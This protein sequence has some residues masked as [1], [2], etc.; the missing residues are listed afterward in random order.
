MSKSPFVEV[1]ITNSTKLAQDSQ[2][3]ADSAASEVT[4][5]NDHNL[6]SVIEKQTQR[7]QFV[8]LTSQYNVILNRAKDDNI[9]TT[10]LTTAYNNLNAFMSVI[11]TD[12]TKASDINRDTYNS[13]I[14]AY[15]TALSSVQS[16]LS[17]SYNNDISNMQSSVSTASQ[18]ASEAT[19]VASSAAAVGSNAADVGNQAL[20]A[21]KAAGDAYDK[22]KISNRNLA[23]MSAPGYVDT[24]STTDILLDNDALELSDPVW[25]SFDWKVTQAGNWRINQVQTN[26]SDLWNDIFIDSSN[27][28]TDITATSGNLSGH[29]S[30]LVYWYPI[31]AGTTQVRLHVN[32]TSP[33]G[34]LTINNF[35]LSNSSK[36]VM[37]TPAETVLSNAVIGTAQIKDAAI[38]DAKISNLSANKITAGTI[39]ASKITVTNIDA[40]KITVGKIGANQLQVGSLSA[41]S[42]D[43]GKVT[44][45]S[46]KG[47]DI[48]ANTFSTPDGSFTTD[49]NGAITAT[50]LT[51]LGNK[52]FVYNSELLG[53]A[54]GWSL[55]NGGHVVNNSAHAGTL[56]LNW[57]S[58]TNGAN[59]VRTARSKLMPVNYTNDT[60]FS[61]SAWLLVRQ[62]TEGI[63]F[64]VTIIFWD[65]SSNQVGSKGAS[66]TSDGNYQ[67]WTLLTIENLE[68]PS[69]ASYV[70]IDYNVYNGSGDFTFSQPMI[71]QGSKYQGYQP[72][73][74][75]VISA[76]EI[77]GSV[78]NGSTISGTT[79]NAGVKDTISTNVDSLYPLTISTSGILTANDFQSGVIN[80]ME[81]DGT[82]I[83]GKSRY[84]VANNGTYSAYDVGIGTS[85]ITISHGE[86]SSPDTTFSQVVN[87]PVDY[88]NIF[89]TTGIELAGNS[90]GIS[91]NGTRA[92]WIAGAGKGI[93]F[94]SYGNI[95][96]NSGQGTW[97]LGASQSNQTANFGIDSAGSNPIK[98]SRNTTIG[99]LFLGTGHTIAMVD[100]QPLYFNKTDSTGSRV[101][102][103]AGAVN[104]TSLVKSSL[105]SVKK[106]VKKADTAYWAQLVNSID[107]ATYQYKSDD[108]TSHL[109]LSSIVDD[110]NDTK[111]WRL[112]DV[113]INRDENGKLNGVDDSVL[114]NA[115][116]ATVQEQQKEIDQL[117][118][119]NMEL[120]ARLN[121][122]EAKLNG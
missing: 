122:L 106:D 36:E 50:R 119:H 108:N 41:V 2:N 111:Q 55:L 72:D 42:A 32:Q 1:N 104:Y 107:L 88:L 76:G 19:I 6:M 86:L 84:L 103:Y 78:I 16:A 37:W 30:S 75:N 87:D 112:P 92:E 73:T 40:S 54:V 83:Y 27:S 105:L 121:K 17:N 53:N 20:A 113:F 35:I 44:A 3:T 81:M 80:Q 29:Y 71:N 57:N 109:R 10:D 114:L 56:G 100:G 22:L 11:L 64:N 33:V 47:V 120:E 68:M 26:S 118:G 51:L 14:D 116:L 67:D 69:T 102:I 96:A 63:V 82:G 18:V 13:L 65:S 60:A 34:T 90:M 12:T 43:L 5:L 24:N 93:A 39:D 4:N 77:D 15:N 28:G 66:Y 97:Y 110:V 31:Q 23:L 117:N 46:L 58:T 95:T 52:N 61:G 70:S 89:G 49:S 101:D 48:V 79:I 59:W 115:T 74:G 7:N 8:G 62:A 25:V 85:G 45:G 9:S 98:F 21:G 99:N 38:T 91:F 94:S